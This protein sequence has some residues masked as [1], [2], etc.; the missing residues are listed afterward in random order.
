VTRQLLLE[1]LNK[2]L[3]FDLTLL[4]LVFL[5]SWLTVLTLGFRIL[6]VDIKLNRI[7]PGALFGALI[8]LFLKPFVPGMTPFFTILVPM[9]LFLKFY[10]KTKWVIASWVTFLVILSTSIGPLVV[11][12]PLAGS[13]HALSS[14]FFMTSYGVM[15]IT[16]AETLIPAILLAFLKIFNIS[17]IPRS[18]KVLTSI[19]F[20]DVYLFGALLFLC[21]HLFMQIWECAK[22]TPLQFLIKPG[23][24]FM[25]A[26][27]ALIALYIKKVNDQKK[28]EV[29]NQD[30]WKEDRNKIKDLTKTNNRLTSEYLEN[31]KLLGLV[32][33]QISDKQ[34]IDDEIIDQLKLHAI[35][36]DNSA[37]FKFRSSEIEIINLIAEGKSNDEIGKETHR[38]PNTVRGMISEIL[39]KAKVENRTELTSWAAENKLLRKEQKE[40][41]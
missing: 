6:K 19:D 34:E 33:K 25:V 1:I 13:N 20:V 31:K 38:S 11:I 24:V 12:V 10:G 40:E 39:K 29:F 16:I 37:K 8:S 35:P 9:F 21:Y 36:A 27:A 5:V 41:N 30:E 7:L 14:F 28:F 3:F 32:L 18:G 22:N 23:I 4:V 2:R 26:A 15:I 17:L